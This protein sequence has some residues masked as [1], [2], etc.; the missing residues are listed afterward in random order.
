[1]KGCFAP[2]VVHA[3]VSGFPLTVIHINRQLYLD[4]LAYRFKR[5]KG[6]QTWDGDM[7]GYLEEMGGGWLDKNILCTCIQF[8][9]N[10]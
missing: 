10:R 7:V 9:K 1:M 3:L 4:S 8:S 2:L 6:I 5:Q